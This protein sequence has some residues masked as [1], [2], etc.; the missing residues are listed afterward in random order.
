MIMAIPPSSTF[1][2]M[3]TVPQ[4]GSQG[5][6]WAM[7]SRELFTPTG[8]SLGDNRLVGWKPLLYI[9]DAGPTPDP[10]P[11]RPSVLRAGDVFHMAHTACCGLGFSAIRQGKLIFAVGEISAVPLGSGI[12]VRTPGDLIQ[13]AQAVFRRRDPEFEFPELPIEVSSH[14]TSS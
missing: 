4:G 7:E 1:R 3:T 9:S 10:S 5:C 6:P 2:Y 12:R 8:D 14:E 13:E 11:S